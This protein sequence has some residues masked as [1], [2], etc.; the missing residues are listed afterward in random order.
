M[1]A[2]VATGSKI[3][4]G[5]LCAGWPPAKPVG[6]EPTR[7]STLRCGGAGGRDTLEYLWTPRLHPSARDSC[8]GRVQEVCSR[9]GRFHT[10]V[11]TAL[12]VS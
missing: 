8:H 1:S 9:E 2:H 6:D 3:T 5:L 4:A 7:T 10:M 12:V 11:I